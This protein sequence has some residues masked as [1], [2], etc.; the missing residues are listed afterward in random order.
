MA[1]FDFAE[2]PEE[3]VLW[4]KRPAWREFCGSLLI[5][6]ALL[7]LYGIGFF[8]LLYVFI[9]RFRRLYFV[10]GERV[11]C[12][13]GILSRDVNEVDIIDLRDISLHQSLWQRLL[14][15]GDVEFSSAGRPGVEVTFRGV[16]RPREI[17]DIV[18]RRKRELQRELYRGAMPGEFEDD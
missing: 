7:P 1:R 17:Q 11:V 6:A 16:W 3:E 15:T 14:G 13:S 12:E 10:T 4:E 8:V 9:E 2:E 5:G 18:R